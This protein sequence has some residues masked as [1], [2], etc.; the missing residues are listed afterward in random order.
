L[1]AQTDHDINAIP[2]YDNMG[3]TSH[4]LWITTP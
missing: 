4:L 3:L 2:T 1:V